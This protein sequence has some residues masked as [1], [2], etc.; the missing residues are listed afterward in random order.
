MVILWPLPIKEIWNM[1]SQWQKKQATGLSDWLS[2]AIHQFQRLPLHQTILL[3]QHSQVFPCQQCLIHPWITLSWWNV[4]FFPIIHTKFIVSQ[5]TYRFT[6]YSQ[7][8]DDVTLAPV[9]G[10]FDRGNPSISL[11]EA[12]AFFPFDYSKYLWTAYHHVRQPRMKERI[13]SVPGLTEVSWSSNT[14]KTIVFSSDA[15][16]WFIWEIL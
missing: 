7:E 1:Y 5:P 4:S 3:P 15:L 6:A 10:L 16:P 9:E 14:K 2:K 12:I 13:A 8:E 11:K